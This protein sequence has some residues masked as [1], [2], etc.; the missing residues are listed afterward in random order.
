M[1]N[2]FFLLLTFIIVTIVNYNIKL[3]NAQVDAQTDLF[4]TTSQT[5]SQINSSTKLYELIDEKN[6]ELKKI[7]EQRENLEKSME[8]VNQLKSS[9]QKEIKT[10]DNNINQ[11]NLLIKANELI[12]D[13][14]DLEI[15]SL[16]NEIND[17]GKN[18]TN[19]REMIIKLLIALQQKDKENFL[20]SFLKGN[21]LSQSLS[22]AE[23]IAT[24]NNALLSS[25][26]ELKNLQIEL[27]QKLEISN[28]KKR[29][30]EIERENLT[31][32]QYIIND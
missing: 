24:L 19:S 8:N 22:E 18:I 17:T 30:R 10:I 27:S 4:Q 1:K 13:K 21:N 32:R 28:S 5:N 20:F 16:N 15:S 31:N 3:V 29:S 12:L 6:K 9:I 14:L 23:S 26:N 11:L 7:Q 2:L 25:I